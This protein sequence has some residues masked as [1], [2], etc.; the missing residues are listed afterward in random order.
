VAEQAKAITEQEKKKR[1]TM[2]QE[3][4]KEA[5]ARLLKEDEALSKALAGEIEDDEDLGYDMNEMKR[6]MNKIPPLLRPCYGAQVIRLRKALKP[7]VNSPFFGLFSVSLVL[8][9]CVFMGL[10]VELEPPGTEE[11]V[12][13]LVGLA[14]V[15]NVGFV[16]EWAM[17]FIVGGA[18]WLKDPLNIV[19][20]F[21]AWLPIIVI[22]W[23]TETAQVRIVIRLLQLGKVVHT[24]KNVQGL[25]VIWL[26]TSGLYAAAGTLFWSCTLLAV[27]VLFFSIISV[28]YIGYAPEWK[29]APPD[30]WARQ[31]T[32]LGNAMMVMTRFVNS[33]GSM[34]VLEELMTEQKEVWIF[35]LAFQAISQYVILNLITA[36]ICD[37][38]MK[39]V[40][41]DQAELA[42]HAD[43]E[44][45]KL[46]KELSELFML[47]DADGNGEV[48]I[49][50]FDDAFEMPALKTKLLQLEVG[51]KAEFKKL[52][53]ALDVDG[54]GAM[55]VDEFCEGIPE[56]FGTA[57]A[58][59]LL[60]AKK[61][62]E[63][64][65]KTMRKLLRKYDDDE[66]HHHGGKTHKKKHKKEDGPSAGELKIRAEIKAL[67][68]EVE[69]RLSSIDDQ[70][71]RSA[72]NI[73]RIGIALAPSAD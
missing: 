58:Y 24:I 11:K 30:S 55:N 27:S 40:Q 25:K 35:L 23:S 9:S 53:R 8:L 49:Q 6:R 51:D 50:E 66:S 4:A 62:A 26:L 43:E 73:N 69:D 33:D 42:N 56:L 14:W 70:I 54:S 57:T 59:G 20:T 16:T 64:A 68:N 34:D 15:M 65:E 37:N 67:E 47:L 19:F 21:A 63:R 31:F 1:Q 60:K 22:P 13:W 45:D 29:D 48:S 61:K 38:S 44:K 3:R 7:C 39:L 17:R 2:R 28:D 41:E 72:K 10:E 5:N 71:R 52:C 12:G 36:V 18:F 32:S 46:F